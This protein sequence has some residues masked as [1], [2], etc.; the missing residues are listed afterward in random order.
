MEMISITCGIYNRTQMNLSTKQKQTHGHRDQT[1]GSQAEV[2][3]GE[4]YTGSL[5]LIDATIDT[6]RMDKQQ[7]LD[8]YH[9]ELFSISSDKP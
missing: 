6:F 1:G 4:R 7:R 2:G 5:G 8:V 3:K 9:R